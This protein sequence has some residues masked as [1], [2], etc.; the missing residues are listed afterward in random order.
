MAALDILISKD[1]SSEES[2][3][4]FLLIISVKQVSGRKIDLP[5]YC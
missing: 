3:S 2:N 5:I 4:A 1:I